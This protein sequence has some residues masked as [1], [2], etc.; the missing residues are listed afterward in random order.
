MRNQRNEVL[1]FVD[2]LN[3]EI[4]SS[5]SEVDELKEQVSS[6]KSDLEKVTAELFQLKL[7]TK[8]NI[9]DNLLENCEN[10]KEREEVTKNWLGVANIDHFL[11]VILPKISQNPSHFSP[12][13]DKSR[14]VK[15]ML[16]WIRNGFTMKVASHILEPERDR[17]SMEKGVRD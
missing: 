16:S 2:D 15:S 13:W 17:Y 6:L 14:F 12:S 9:L 8:R 11:S 10:E 3:I 7:F 4:I 5:K 1:G